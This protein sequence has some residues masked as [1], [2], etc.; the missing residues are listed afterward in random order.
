M[1]I[2]DPSHTSPIYDE[3]RND[4]IRRGLELADITI[5]HRLRVQRT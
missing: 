2:S 5:A 4:I 3:V 1:T